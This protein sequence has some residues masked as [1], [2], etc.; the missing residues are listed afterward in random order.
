MSNQPSSQTP[1]QVTVEQVLHTLLHGE[2]EERGLLPYS[3]NYSFLVLVREG[4]LQLPAV[5]KPRRGENPLWDF[6]SGTLCLRET[7]AYLVSAALDWL[8]VPPTVL[9]QGPRGLGSVQLFIQADPDLHY[10]NMQE[11]ARFARLFRQLTLFDAVI[12]N[13][14]R[15]AGHCLFTEE[16]RL[17]AIDHGICFHH[18]YKL[19][20]VLWEYSGQPIEADF[21][22]HLEA[23]QQQLE[24][25][26]SP[27][28]TQLGELLDRRELAALCR[29]T[30]Q[31]LSS[32]RYPSPSPHHRNFPWPPI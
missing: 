17:W 11:D 25:Q 24:D 9:R 22:A 2:I 7:A 12:N 16:G 26:D 19:R 27:L 5:Y 4:A 1:I 29:R 23:L 20:T 18:Q 10:F 30:E 15:K 32:K 6:P 13:A 28:R 14:D 3:S 8:L 21:L 31:I